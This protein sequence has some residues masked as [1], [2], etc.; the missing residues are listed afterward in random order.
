MNLR[1]SALP[2]LM[3]APV[4]RSN[5]DIYNDA[6]DKAKAL[7]EKCENAKNKET[8]TFK[9]DLEKLTF[10]EKEL[11]NL[12]AKKDKIQLSETAKSY[13]KQIAKEDFYGYESEFSNKYTQKGVQCEQESINLLNLVYFQDFVKNEIRITNDFL[14]GEA[15]IVTDDE[16]IDIKTSW[17]LDTFPALPSDI[18]IKDYEMQLRG[19]MMLYEKSKA[20]VCYC[21]VSTPEELCM[22]ENQTLHKVDHI[23]PEKRVTS[24]SIERDLLIEVRIK[25]VCLEAI[26][27]YNDYINQLNNK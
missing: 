19:Y 12:E 24:L 2:K 14:T 16:I 22:Y 7:K 5:M 11:P 10:L 13:I 25:S 23:A 17:S 8:A 26:E 21:M 1:A 3:T 6:I 9:K 18:N 27:F 4:G 15:D 20:T